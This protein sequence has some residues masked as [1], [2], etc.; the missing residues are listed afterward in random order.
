MFFFWLKDVEL[1]NPKPWP[2][3]PKDGYVGGHGLAPNLGE[4][5]WSSW[6]V[7]QCGGQKTKKTEET[8]SFIR[9]LINVC[10][11]SLQLKCY[12]RNHVER[13]EG[14][15]CFIDFW[16][17]HFLERLME[18]ILLPWWLCMAWCWGSAECIW[19]SSKH[20]DVC[21]SSCSVSAGC[22]QWILEG[23]RSQLLCALRLRRCWQG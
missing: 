12:Y 6:E 16:T 19:T 4:E 3:S 14:L 7:G 11:Y 5:D 22:C 2:S 21:A 13:L 18:S 1:K 10:S 8:K 9:K 23:V 15:F 17:W 20:F